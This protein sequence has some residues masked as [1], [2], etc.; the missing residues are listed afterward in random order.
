[1]TKRLFPAAP[2]TGGNL[3]IPGEEKIDWKIV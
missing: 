2:I 1:M 3:V